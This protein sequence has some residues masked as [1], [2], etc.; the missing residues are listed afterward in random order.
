ML[1]DGRLLDTVLG[2]NF[3][4][5]GEPS[6]LDSV[7]DATRKLWQTQGVVVLTARDPEVRAWFEQQGVR[8]VIIRPDRY[9]LGT[10][11]SGVEL[12]SISALLPTAADLV[13]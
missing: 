12:D 7:S 11:Q 13:H 4:V 8:A 2:L 1:A 10:A 6:V 3:A 5:I 9:I